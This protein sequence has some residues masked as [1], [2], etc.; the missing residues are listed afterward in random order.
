MSGTFRLKTADA[1]YVVPVECPHRKGWLK[2]GKVNRTKHGKCFLV[3]PLHFSTFDLQTGRQVS[4]PAAHDLEIVKLE[5]N[6]SNGSH[7]DR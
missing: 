5:G 3:C 6:L 7:V 4:G 2:C 1:E